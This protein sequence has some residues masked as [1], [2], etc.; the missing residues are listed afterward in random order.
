MIKVTY[1]DSDGIQATVEFEN[2]VD[3]D[4]FTERVSQEGDTIISIDYSGVSTLNRL[5]NF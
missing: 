1:K 4:E 5:Y 2:Q 3:A